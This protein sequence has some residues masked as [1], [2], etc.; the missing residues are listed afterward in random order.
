M[1]QVLYRKYRPQK[2]NEVVGQDI[3][4][5]AMQQALKSGKVGHAYIFSGP[6][7]TG[8]TTVARLLS[9]AVNCQNNKES[10]L[11]S[12]E[13]CNKCAACKNAQANQ[14]IDLIE[15]DAASNRG[16][17][18]IRELRESVRFAPQGGGKK[19][20]LIDEFHMLTKEAFNALLKTLEEPPE[21]AIFILATT[22]IHNVPA[23]IMS[24]A[25]HF[26][27]QAINIE[28]LIKTITNIAAKEKIAIKPEAV[29]LIA[30]QAE[31]GAR[32]ALSLLQTVFTSSA[33]NK[34]T[35]QNV[36]STLALPEISQLEGWIDAVSQNDARKA[37]EIIQATARGGSE[38]TQFA[39]SLI[40]YVR[41]IALAQVSK[42]LIES[43]MPVL[44]EDQRKTLQG[45][46]RSVSSNTL[47]EAMSLLNQASNEAKLATMPTLPL[48]VATLRIVADA[49]RTLTREISAP[50]RET[51]IPVKEAS[52]PI[53]K[54]DAPNA[55]KKVPL[56]AE[57]IIESD[58]LVQTNHDLLSSLVTR[59]SE[60][61]TKITEQNF[62]I[63]NLLRSAHLIKVVE[64]EAVFG[65]DY[66]FH[67][68]RMMTRTNRHMIESILEEMHGQKLSIRC[69]TKSE[70][71]KDDLTVYNERIKAKAA[72][73]PSKTEP[74][75]DLALD[76][77]GGRV[78]E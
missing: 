27:F 20:Y 11:D 76:L 32:D 49:A 50:K 1:S 43:A 55:P 40:R 37:I 72:S 65:V 63:G 41:A 64:Q 13:P 31:G 7:G 66:E 56:Q 57:R 52:E 33:G 54:T 75:A 15:I 77:L 8:K 18:E 44:T 28:D 26:V 38:P 22:E 5:G 45:F 48:E 3:I 35:E 14:N 10:K 9:R 58:N 23:T 69:L 68:E 53:K 71:S 46:T 70:L 17:D 73:K 39:N 30:A 59:W 19:V 60:A 12:G 6:R 34:I 36:I 42:D 24:R 67:R 51:A 62:G 74:I 61:L 16:I 25:Q 29:S 78:V 2:F 21:H 4:V 47:L